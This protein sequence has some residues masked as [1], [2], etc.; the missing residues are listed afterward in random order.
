MSNDSFASFDAAVSYPITYPVVGWV[1][2]ASVIAAILFGGGFTFTAFHPAYAH[3]PLTLNP[4]LLVFDA[5]VL[6]G[7]AYMLCWAFTARVVLHQ[8]MFEQHK[9][10]SNRTLSVSDIEGRRYTARGNYPVIVPRSG[11]AFS[12]DTSAYGLDGRFRAWLQQLPD[13]AKADYDRELSRVQKDDTLGAT[14]SERVANYVQRKR[15]FSQITMVLTFASYLMLLLMRLMPDAVPHIILVIAVLPW[16]CI[17]L[18]LYFRREIALAD[19]KNAGATLAPILFQSMLLMLVAMQYTSLLNAKGVVFWGALAGLPLLL[20]VNAFSLPPNMPSGQRFGLLA[21][22][23]ILAWI[24]G[25]SALALANCM[26]DKRP[27]QVYE[28]QVVGGY[29]TSGKGGLRHYL[30]LAPWGPETSGSSLLVSADRYN[31]THLHDQVCMG[32]Y[33]GRFGFAWMHSVSCPPTDA[34]TVSP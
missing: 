16:C 17:L 21:L 2:I 3:G 23:A 24:Y 11:A 8:N 30:K 10:F 22:C 13:L 26:L 14:Q 19:S 1:R 33:S 18:D 31:Q 25:G 12:L 34:G 9:P 20:A 6:L 7:V 15:Y 32:V 5:I 27:P 29:T 4:V 28:T